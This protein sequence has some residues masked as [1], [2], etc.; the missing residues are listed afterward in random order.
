[1]GLWIFDRSG[2][3]SSGALDIHCEPEKLARALVAYATMGDEEMGLDQSIEWKE[4]HGYVTVEGSD[5]K[6]KR[7]ELNQ[8]LNRQR[9]VVCRGIACFGAKQGVVKFSWRSARRQPSAVNHLKTTREKGV[10]EVAELVEHR[11]IISIADLR[12]GLE[13]SKQTRHLFKAT[14]RSIGRIQPLKLGHQWLQRKKK[15]CRRRRASLLE[16]TVQQP[17]IRASAGLRRS[18]EQEID[19]KCQAKSLCSST[20]RPIRGS[21]T[22]L[23]RDLSC[24][25]RC[26]RSS[27]RPRAS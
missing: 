27:N 16:A 3:Y 17:K 23:S 2:A 7:V 18:N 21:Y 19:W 8:L 6:D 10:E 9:A 26:R 11:E 5:G 4:K 24:W 20:G 14:T 15:V 22:V 13:F 1:M 25:T 12:A